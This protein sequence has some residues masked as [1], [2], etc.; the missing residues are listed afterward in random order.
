MPAPLLSLS[1]GRFKRLALRSG[2]AWQGGLFRLP[3]WVDEGPEG[4]PYRPWGGV[5]VSER[6]GLVHVEAEPEFGAHGPDLALTALLEFGLRE[7]KHLG[8]RAARL[9]VT[10]PDLA[11]Y[12]AGQLDDPDTAIDVV[13]DLPAVADVLGEMAKEL[14]GAEPIAPALEAPGATVERLRAFAEAA[15]AFYAAAPWEHLQNED[16]IGVESPKWPRNLS[17]VAV[18]GNAGINY[19]LAFFDSAA[20]FERMAFSGMDVAARV[21]GSSWAVHF[22]P[23]DELPIPDADAW[24]QH[25]LPVAGERA[26]PCALRLETSG[27]VRRAD[28]RELACLEAL[29]RALAVT[30][31]DQLD[32]GEWSVE[33]VSCDGPRTLSLTLPLLLQAERGTA[34]GGARGGPDRR[35]IERATGRVHRF[36]KSREFASLEEANEALA[37]AQQAGLFADDAAGSSEALSPL[38]QAQELVYD[39]AEVAGRLRVKRARQALAISPDCA[40]AWVML[41]E[42]ASSGTR[43]REL[44]EQ[45]VAAGERA[46]G[47]GA[48]EEFAGHF[49]GHIETRPYM[50]AR[51]G[52]GELLERLGERDAAASQYQELLRLNPSD[53]QGARYVLLALLLVLG[54][55]ADAQVLLHQYEDDIAAEWVYGRALWMY[56]R[57]GDGPQARESLRRA[58]EVNPHVVRFLLDPARMPVELPPHYAFGSPEEAASCAAGLRQGWEATAG[59][60]AWLRQRAHREIGPWS[61]RSRPRRGK[62]S[63]RR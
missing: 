12:L 16:L 53:N 45:A 35:A 20:D 37:A 4:R 34:R 3:T 59:A 63:R 30:T 14:S 50:R 58:V 17:R 60:L 43:A 10:D 8:G 31:E 18:M 13:S 11:A 44:Y 61:S 55:D 38:E 57:H 39:A 28:A 26:Y 41:A 23:L 9:R 33:V 15:A 19:G 6:T 22:G 5:W 2:D 46:L 48:F 62:P 25:A 36:L 40:D 24:E 21:P 7:A 27:G 32:A 54:R 56:R 49:W 42:A 1:L 51:F 52:L 47:P 29:L